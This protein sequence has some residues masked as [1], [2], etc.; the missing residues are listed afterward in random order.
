MKVHARR[1]VCVLD[2]ERNL[3]F[4]GQKWDLAS[5]TFQ[6]DYEW[7]SLPGL[8]LWGWGSPT[9]SLNSP[10]YLLVTPESRGNLCYN[11]LI[12]ANHQ[13]PILSDGALTGENAWCNPSFELIS[14]AEVM[15]PPV[16]SEHWQ[17]RNSREKHCLEAFTWWP[18]ERRSAPHVVKLSAC[19][20]DII[21]HSIIHKSSVYRPDR[22]LTG[23]QADKW[24]IS[25][26]LI[27]T[28][29]MWCRCCPPAV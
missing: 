11:K 6:P 18:F 29:N 23:C 15:Q 7:V 26:C 12:T 1:K 19:S 14:G 8:V 3:P 28:D 24:P 16:V 25:G 4:K 2:F 5:I 27:K 20:H 9:G 21:L 10:L 17:S 22:H 13:F